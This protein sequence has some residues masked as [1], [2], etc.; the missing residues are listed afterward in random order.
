M[1]STAPNEK[2]PTK[3]RT[4]R[5]LWLIFWV[6]NGLGL[7]LAYPVIKATWPLVEIFWKTRSASV[8]ASDAT[9]QKDVDS[10]LTSDFNRLARDAAEG[11]DQEVLER[12]SSQLDQIGE[13]DQEELDQWAN[14]LF[15]EEASELEPADF[16]LESSSFS[17]IEKKVREVD[18]QTY[19]VYLI[20]LIDRKGHKA[21]RM[22]AYEQPDPDFE[23]SMLTL[24]LIDE[25]PQLK[26]IYKAFSHVIGKSAHSPEG[27]GE[28]SDL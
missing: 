18:G 21:Y 7:L 2:P 24:K 19:H 5:R 23:R 17:R 26:K 27:S 15:G 13:L 4:H 25:N 8:V 1:H 22:A 9:F 6:L 11:D 16:D 14:R 28:D 12:L 10:D 3:K 20:E